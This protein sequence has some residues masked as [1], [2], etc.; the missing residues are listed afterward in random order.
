MLSRNVWQ[1][2]IMWK[3]IWGI[4]AYE[5]STSRYIR[6][7][8]AGNPKRDAAAIRF[9]QYRTGMTVADYFLAGE[10]LDVPNYPTFDITW[11]SDPGRRLIKLYD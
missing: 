6:K 10:K 11:D 3:K 5:G 2:L 7:L 9:A 4:Q 8:V 1:G